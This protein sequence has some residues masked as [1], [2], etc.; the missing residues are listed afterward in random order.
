MLVYLF[1]TVTFRNQYYYLRFLRYR[2]ERILNTAEK[3][4][5]S[6]STVLRVPLISTLP[7]IIWDS[8]KYH[9]CTKYDVIDL[10]FIQ[11]FKRCTYRRENCRPFKHFTD[12]STLKYMKHTNNAGKQYIIKNILF[13]SRDNFDLTRNCTYVRHT[14]IM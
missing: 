14:Y 1:H 12:S 10:H 11:N 2:A 13:P 9:L 3:M 4:F 7:F 8:M 6:I 5:S